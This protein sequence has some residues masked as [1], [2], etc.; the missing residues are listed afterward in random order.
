MDVTNSSVINANIFSKC[1]IFSFFLNNQVID[2][3]NWFP[4]DNVAKLQKTFTVYLSFYFVVYCSFI[5][6]I[7]KSVGTVVFASILVLISKGYTITRWVKR[8]FTDYSFSLKIYHFWFVILLCSRC[9]KFREKISWQLLNSKY[10]IIKWWLYH[11]ERRIHWGSKYLQE[12]G[13]TEDINRT[14]EI[15]SKQP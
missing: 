11:W 15:D 4:C 3:L 1:N 14:I 13:K 10:Q 9:S 5:G 2:I 8:N 12:D 6:H 7:L